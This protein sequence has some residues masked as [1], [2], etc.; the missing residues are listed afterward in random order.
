MDWTLE[1]GIMGGC[2]CR[3]CVYWTGYRFIN[4]ELQVTAEGCLTG[5][6]EKD[7]RAGMHWWLRCIVAKDL[8][9]RITNV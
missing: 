5:I 2:H 4:H 1:S 3:D 7:V 9:I 8:K 6:G